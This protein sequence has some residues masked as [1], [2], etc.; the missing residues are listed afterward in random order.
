MD[1]AQREMQIW[2]GAVPLRDAMRFERQAEAHLEELDRRE[3]KHAP[4]RAAL[5][6]AAARFASAL[7]HRSKRLREDEGGHRR[8]ELQAREDVRA[9]RQCAADC[10]TQ[11]AKAEA[12]I[13]RLRGLLRESG[14]ERE[15]LVTQ[16]SLVPDE[17]GQ[18]ALPR[19]ESAGERLRET[20]QALLSSI[21]SSR[22]KARSL[23]D[24]KEDL[25][26]K[27][28]R[29]HAQ[30]E[31]QERVL[32]RATAVRE[33]LEGD[34]LLRRHLEVEEVDLERVGEQILTQLHEAARQTLDLIVRLKVERAE[35]ERA[36]L[37]LEEHGLLPPERAVE[38]VLAFLRSHL[39]AVW[40]G[41]TYIESNAP[42]AEAR[43]EWIRRWRL[44]RSAHSAAT[45]RR[46]GT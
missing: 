45:M 42:T 22:Q 33:A 6:D 1:E 41:W 34:P 36:A 18:A 38:T 11:G 9:S 43:R 29:S 37:H 32:L 24:E 20:R 4:T 14:E 46:V 40:S 30:A 31:A 28:S 44:H 10:Q 23:R 25:S 21:Q 8:H 17:T 27:A 16:G 13:K 3:K 2:D 15:R 5:D 12:E 39:P 7:A 35:G 26:S 19:L